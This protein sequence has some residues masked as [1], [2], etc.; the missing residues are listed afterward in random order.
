MK[1]VAISDLHGY[2][3]EIP[4][5]DLLLIAG[6]LCPTYDHHPDWQSRWLANHF[7]AWLERVPAKHIVGIAGNHD[8]VFE[9]TP[10]LVPRDLRW[11][12]LQDSG[13]EIAGL[14]LYGT[15]LCGYS[16]DLRL[17]STRLRLN[18]ADCG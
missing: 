13:T 7:G 5:C 1:I 3:P 6:D 14:K 8:F 16:T 12:Y 4:P 15:R 18:W 11:T 2:L 9:Q 10:H 17:N